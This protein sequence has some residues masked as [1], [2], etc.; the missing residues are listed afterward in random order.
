MNYFL[1]DVASYLFTLNQGDF[2]NTIIVF[3]NRRAR[4][5]FNKHLSDLTDKPLWSPQYYSISDFVAKYSGVQIA[6]QLTLIFQL[7]KVYIKVTGSQETFD[8]FYHYSETILSD[9]D[10][11]DKYCIDASMLYKNLSE[12]K[13]F[14]NQ[15][16][17][18]TEQ[19]IKIIKEFWGIFIS[20]RD[21]DEKNQ[22]ASFWSA[23]KEI[24]FRFNDLLNK[25]GYGYEGKAYK[26]LADSIKE[27]SF[28]FPDHFQVVFVGFNALNQAEESIFKF[29]KRRG[30]ALFFWDYDESYMKGDVREAGLFLRKYVEMF[31]PPS[32]FSS[33]T[34][35]KNPLNEVVSFSVPSNVVQAKILDK[36]IAECKPDSIDN[37]GQTAVVLADESLLLPVITSMPSIFDKINISMGYPIIDT[38]AFNFI[39]L[40]AEM[41]GKLKWDERE[42][43]CR[44]Y[45]YDYFRILEHPYFS[46]V[47]EDTCFLS[48]KKEVQDKNS[49]FIDPAGYTNA[50]D[51]YI[52][53]FSPVTNPRQFANYLNEVLEMVVS[54]VL[55][56]KEITKEIQWH[57]EVIYAIYKVLA[58]FQL[59][60][61]DDT[62]NPSLKTLYQILKKVLKGISVPFAGEPLTGLQ[63]MGILET[64][65]LD[66][67]NIIVLSMNEGKFPR[68]SSHNTLIPFALREG[69]G[70]NTFKHQDAIYAYYFYRLLHRARKVVLVHHTKT[71]G[72]QKGEPSRYI[73]QLK[74]DSKFAVREVDLG[75][76]VYPVSN[77]TITADKDESVIRK[78]NEYLRPDGNGILSPSALNTYLNCSLRFYYRYI[79]GLKEP[80]SIEEDIENNMFGSILHKAIKLIYEKFEG[81]ILTVSDIKTLLSDRQQISNKINQAFAEEYFK[82]E[83]IDQN[84]LTGRNLLVRKVIEKYINGILRFDLQQAPIHLLALEKT[85]TYDYNFSMKNGKITIGGN[86]DR[87]DRKDGIFRVIDY[88]TGKIKDKFSTLECL[89]DELPSLRNDAAFQTFLYSYILLKSGKYDEILPSLFFLRNIHD[90]DSN[91]KIKMN[92]EYIEKFTT[93]LSPFEQLL[94][95]KLTDFYNPNLSYIQTDDV[96][97]CI[98]CPYNSICMRRD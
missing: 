83:I 90:T 57:I 28:S 17:Y 11:L 74:Y 38:P 47:S 80:D 25:E 46:E 95:Q 24:Y 79:K 61:S 42:K 22:F 65:A 97:Y 21:S 69:F 13:E 51:L 72:L 88:K 48:F 55:S 49:S 1:K 50:T 86:I 53:V 56:K 78:L 30:D 34:F 27:H 15:Y 5:F 41:Q 82:K 68:T 93:L 87:L 37:P 43:K 54:A 33:P 9:F 76:R 77:H 58:R 18:L 59:V 2:R 66:F 39:N 60:I 84:E 73:L 96:K 14:E 40:L 36:C 35:L 23:L 94:D 98:N 32:G 10:E 16:D 92:K 19:Q 12:L 29:F 52:K 67:E 45:H 70:L 81:K 7:Y 4:L 31:A 64:R 8:S 20:T 75:Y 89:F 71:D 62:I 91:F 85:F 6:D 3:P 44:I 26:K 63:I